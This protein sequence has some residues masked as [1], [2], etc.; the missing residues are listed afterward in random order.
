M[1][2]IFESLLLDKVQEE[3][4]EAVKEEIKFDSGDS[5]YQE[6][7]KAITSKI[8]FNWFKV[9]SIL[10][11]P[12]YAFYLFLIHRKIVLMLGNSKI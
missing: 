4:N 11:T 5:R 8:T 10:L 6:E 7:L 2:M 12:I 9:R 3:I 1:K